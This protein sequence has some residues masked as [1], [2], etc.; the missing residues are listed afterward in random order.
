MENKYTIGCIVELKSGSPK[1]TIQI[2]FLYEKE[3]QC[4]EYQCQWFGT[5]KN[6][7]N[8]G[9]FPENSLILV[10]PGNYGVIGSI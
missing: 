2:V 10:E 5:D 9:K 6:T 1:M 3:N 7:L 4:R 8:S